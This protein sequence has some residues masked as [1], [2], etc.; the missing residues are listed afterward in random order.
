MR[1]ATMESGSEMFEREILQKKASCEHCGS[2]ATI[3]AIYHY[4]PEGRS[5]GPINDQSQPQI[6]MILKCPVCGPQ[7]QLKAADC[8][9]ER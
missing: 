4:F 8:A 1:L 6:V 5:I 3:R 2:Q 7:S 9:V